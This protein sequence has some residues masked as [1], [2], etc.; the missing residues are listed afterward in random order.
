MI[1]YGHQDIDVSDI[2]A[3]TSI[4]RSDWLTQGPTIEQFE[5]SV[6]SYCG[7]RF[8]V[9]VNSG[10]SALHIACMACGVTTGDFVWTSPI[11]FV[12]SSNCALYCGAS[13]DFVD[14]D[15]VSYNISVLALE[16]KLAIAARS[17]KLPK[18][19]VVV[20]FSGQPCEMTRLAELARQ[21]G[22][23]IIEDASHALGA[24]Y[25]Q[26][27]IGS[28]AYSDITVF[29]FHPVKII[30]TAEGGMAM[31]NDESLCG[32]LRRLRSH[33]ITRDPAELQFESD[34]PWYYEQQALGYNYRL[35]DIHAALGISQMRRIDGFIE[36][37]RA[38]ADRYNKA[39]ADL[40][41]TLPAQAAHSASSWHLYV[42][43][44]QLDQLSRTRRQ[45]FEALRTADV[46]VNVHYI[47]VHLQPFYQALGFKAGDFPESEAYYKEAITLPLYPGLADEQH[48]LI[49]RAVKESLA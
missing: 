26:S 10:T 40:P 11:T 42:I 37:R 8:G 9:A 20:H 45:I 12:A 43:R 3:V 21:Y 15:P 29:S 6:T 17:G 25:R 44:L 19:V 36:R 14:I 39:L 7:A 48:D 33:G 13:V 4:L 38:L 35:T 2:D 30:T 41:L 16:Q 49:I 47:P 34:G 24:S 28:C 5:H 31:T 1:P 18:V 27:P 46:G 22:F 32:A 23:K